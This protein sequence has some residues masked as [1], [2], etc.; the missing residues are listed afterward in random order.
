MFLED[1]QK[2][3]LEDVHNN[4]ENDNYIPVK[5]HHYHYVLYLQVKT[6]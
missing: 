1:I 3:F 5:K 6:S 2:F 4:N